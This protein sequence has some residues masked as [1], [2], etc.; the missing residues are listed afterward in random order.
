MRS[1]HGPQ[2]PSDSRCRP[3]QEQRRALIARSRPL[4]K[5]RGASFRWSVGCRRLCAAH[6]PA[7]G[8]DHILVVDA[9]I[10]TT[11]KQ[12]AQAALTAT[13]VHQPA[14]CT[15]LARSTSIDVRLARPSFRYGASI[16]QTGS[17][18]HAW[19]SVAQAAKSE[20]M[21]KRSDQQA[22][23]SVATIARADATASSRVL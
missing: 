18:T 2:P 9:A 21:R 20:T 1:R 5:R 7:V 11:R 10:A 19:N 8:G 23:S 16:V 4:G 15:D 13:D 14:R 17:T 22:G 3:A 6:N 12:D